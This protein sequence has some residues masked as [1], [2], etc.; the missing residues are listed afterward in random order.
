MKVRE[1]SAGKSSASPIAR[2]RCAGAHGFALRRILAA[3]LI[4]VLTTAGCGSQKE[5]SAPQPRASLRFA[6]PTL[7][8]K[9]CELLTKA[10]IE[11]ALGVKLKAGKPP[12]GFPPIAVK[13]M[14]HCVFEGVQ[15]AGKPAPRA[16]VG[17][18]SAFPR[19]VFAKYKTDGS[20]RLTPLEGLGAE[21][22]H[23]QFGPSHQIVALKGQK[24][25][26]VS[27]SFLQTDPKQT[28][29]NLMKKA[30]ARA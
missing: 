17:L 10:A 16:S 28:A 6:D 21:A 7:N 13:G 26:G 2:R 18:T 5:A 3:L 30:L 11:R 20:A 14:Q 23:S 4:V 9:P 22:L 8:D 29:I 25:I 15:A 12:T 1:I 24:V 27:V 19:E